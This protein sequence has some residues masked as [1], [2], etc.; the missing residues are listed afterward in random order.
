[1]SDL[2]VSPQ[3]AQK[4]RDLSEQ[5][6]SSVDEILL[7]LLNNYG[8][9]LA[10]EEADVADDDVTWSD[11]E[12][13]ELLKPKKPLTGKE[14][15]EQGLVGGWEDKGIEDSVEWLEQQKARK[16]NKHRW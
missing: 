4:L 6:Q 1:M 2:Q 3:V 8:H 13:A 16:R 15:V 10:P 11:E 5:T 9:M 7:W 12:I 14:M